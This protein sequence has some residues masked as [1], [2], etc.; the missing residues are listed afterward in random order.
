MYAG[1]TWFVTTYLIAHRQGLR[2]RLEEIDMGEGEW[3]AYL[4]YFERIQT[5]VQQLRV[6][7]EA[8]ENK[9]QERSWLRHQSTVTVPLLHFYDQS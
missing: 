4:S 9:S 5:Q 8:I 7:L 6:V 1:T 3:E 2:K